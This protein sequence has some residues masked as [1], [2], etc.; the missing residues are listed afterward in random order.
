M[1]DEAIRQ[2]QLNLARNLGREAFGVVFPGIPFPAEAE[3]PAGAAPPLPAAAPAAADPAAP[4]IAAPPSASTSRRPSRQPPSPTPASGAGHDNPLARF[5]LPELR[6]PP[7][8][9]AG[10]YSAAPGAAPSPTAGFAGVG[11]GL[12]HPGGQA[13][14]QQQARSLPNLEER[15][16]HI[17]ERMA[18]A[19]GGSSAPSV[20]APMTSGEAGRGPSVTVTP[21]SPP[22]G[23]PEVSVKEP[24]TS[25]TGETATSEEVAGTGEVKP[26][27]SAREAALAAAERRAAASS[28]RRTKP[29]P[30]SSGAE[31]LLPATAPVVGLASTPAVDEPQPTPV[32][33]TSPAAPTSPT[34]T[35]SPPTPVSHAPP[36]P[37]RL[38]PLFSS[39]SSTTSY[40]NLLSTIPAP[41]PPS[42]YST[43]HPRTLP[44]V[45]FLPAE[46]TAEQLDEMARLTRR[47]MEE[48]L[49]VLV[50]WQARMEGLATEM[51]GV[52]ESLPLDSEQVEKRDEGK[53]EQEAR[54]QEGQGDKGKR[55]V[56]GIHAHEVS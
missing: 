30:T 13:A 34:S 31:S 32:A 40:P 37:V 39:P 14:A 9:E 20:G 7:T 47:G 11:Y 18:R 8:G 50:G 52:L 44:S 1:G 36:A 28:S 6:L 29:S 42:P 45:P 15:I 56:E 35:S 21:T 19:Q 49:R 46:P 55:P 10:L 48:R 23:G 4:G 5:S 24:E 26:E 53:R 17:R 54:E 12:Y 43:T 51:R 38:I 25:G 41:L 3:G 22:I 27:L 16:K 33:A 2:A